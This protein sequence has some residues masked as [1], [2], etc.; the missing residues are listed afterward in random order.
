M[1]FAVLIERTQWKNV[2][3]NA[4]GHSVSYK[5]SIVELRT[6]FASLNAARAAIETTLAGAAPPAGTHYLFMEE[7]RAGKALKH[8]LDGCGIDLV[9]ATYAI[10]GVQVGGIRNRHSLFRAHGGIA[11]TGSPAQSAA[12][13]YA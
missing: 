1:G 13:A 6:G 11:T 5:R 7:D 3:S 9:A 10:P 2:T 8:L 4:L 12:A